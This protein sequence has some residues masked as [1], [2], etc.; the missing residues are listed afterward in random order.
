MRAEFAAFKAALSEPAILAG[1]VE[2]TVRVTTNNE[3]VRANYVIVF[4]SVPVLDDARYTV[5]QDRDST[6]E[7][8]YDVRVVAVDADGVLLL[9]DAVM[10][11]MLGRV[12]TVAG[13]VCDPIRMPQDNVEEG[14]VSFDSKARLFMLDMTFRF[15]SRRLAS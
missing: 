13:R 3:L 9:A 5:L 4:P 6:R 10:G 15:T 8:E 1:K 2:T 7:L 11:Q 12:L 14:A